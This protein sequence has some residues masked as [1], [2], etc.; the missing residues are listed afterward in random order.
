MLTV[1]EPAATTALTTLDRVKLGLGITDDANDELLEIQILEQSEFVCALLNTAMAADGTRTLGLETVEEILEAPTLSRIPVVE[2]EEVRDGNGTLFDPADYLVDKAT[3][4][5][6]GPASAAWWNLVYNFTPPAI[7]IIVRYK[8][9]WR[10]PGDENRNLPRVIETGAISR[11]TSVRAAGSRDPNVKAEDIPGVLRTEYWV[12]STGGDSSTGG[13]PP[14]IW[15]Q[16]SLY[17]RLS[18]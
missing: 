11:V 3:G 14:D 9:G 8:A 1:I 5:F 10:L 13:I 16:L 17:R 12:G 18:V 4:R 7:P 6:I 2:I 15:S